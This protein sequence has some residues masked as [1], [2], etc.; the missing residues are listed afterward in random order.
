MYGS[1]FRLIIFNPYGHTYKHDEKDFKFNNE[2]S[3]VL[4]LNFNRVTG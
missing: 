1:A 4:A 3:D 2:Y